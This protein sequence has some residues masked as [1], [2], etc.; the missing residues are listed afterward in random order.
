MQLETEHLIVRDYEMTDKVAYYRLKSDGETMHY[1]QDIKLSSMEEADK[2]LA[3]I[4]RDRNCSQRKFYF[5]HVEIKDTFQQV[6]SI[7][8]T[9]MQHTPVGKIVNAGYFM[10]PSF[11]NKGYTT[12]AFQTLLEFAFEQDNVYRVTTGCLADNKGSE[13]VMQKCGLVKE[14]EHIDW[15]WHE[16]RMKTRLEYRMLR[17]EWQI[18]KKRNL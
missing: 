8:Y 18:I 1:L 10:Y 6:G 7:G 13:R 14:A 2:E 15:E 12:E 11:W 4:L 5:F 9:V 16:G 17:Q 3:N